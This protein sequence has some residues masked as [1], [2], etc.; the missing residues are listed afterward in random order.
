MELTT[1]PPPIMRRVSTLK[2]RLP[3]CHL[4]MCNC[5]IETLEP[6]GQIPIRFYH[7]ISLGGRVLSV[8][9]CSGRKSIPVAYLED[10]D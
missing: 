7:I 8:S 3:R 6:G 10:E 4:N 2:L 1:G 5:F 9:I